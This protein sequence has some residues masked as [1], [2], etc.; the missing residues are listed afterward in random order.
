M[1]KLWQIDSYYRLVEATR[2]SFIISLLSEEMLILL[3]QLL[4]S[5]R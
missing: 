4:L 2:D 1:N 5:N 3:V